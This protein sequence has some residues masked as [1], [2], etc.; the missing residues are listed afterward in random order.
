MNE[1]YDLENGQLTDTHDSH[2]CQRASCP[3]AR[4]VRC[5]IATLVFRGTAAVWIKPKV[6][7]NLGSRSRS[8]IR[9]IIPLLYSFYSRD[10]H[11]PRHFPRKVALLRRCWW[12]TMIEHDQTKHPCIYR[13]HT[14]HAGACLVAFTGQLIS[15]RRIDHGSARPALYTLR[16][17]PCRHHDSTS[18]CCEEASKE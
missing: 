3:V 10:R 4:L 2:I 12:W 18:I 9:G 7:C 1:A 17:L 14:H 15:S 13:A 5:M 16:D 6:H 8:S 11:G